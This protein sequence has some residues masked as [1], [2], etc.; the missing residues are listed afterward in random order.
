M[1]PGTDKDAGHA[2][3]PCAGS[4]KTWPAE[5]GTASSPAKA[6]AGR[7]AAT[8]AVTEAGAV[9]TEDLQELADRFAATVDLIGRDALARIAPSRP[10]TPLSGEP[11]RTLAA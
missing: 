2:E 5:S 4:G 10:R 9:L 6:K 7:A 8:I 11:G 3:R 1:S